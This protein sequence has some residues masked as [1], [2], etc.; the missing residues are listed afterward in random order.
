MIFLKLKNSPQK[1]KLILLIKSATNVLKGDNF[2]FVYPELLKNKIIV[3]EE[4]ITSA[5][6]EKKRSWL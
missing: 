6:L 5:I 3:E 1:W 2:V 4:V